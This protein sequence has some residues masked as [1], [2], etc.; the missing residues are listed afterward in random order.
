MEKRL[1]LAL[2]LSAMVLMVFSFLGPKKIT[3]NPAVKQ[4]AQESVKVE[5]AVL[6]PLSYLDHSGKEF[7]IETEVFKIVYSEKGGWIKNLFLKEYK[8]K[9][10]NAVDLINGEGTGGLW[11]NNKDLN[12]EDFKILHSNTMRGNKEVELS[13]LYPNG[14]EIKKNFIFTPNEYDFKFSLEF[15]NHSNE[16]IKLDSLYLQWGPGINVGEETKRERKMYSLLNISHGKELKRVKW[17]KLKEPLRLKDE[18]KWF[19]LNN[20][21]FLVALVPSEKES[22]LLVRKTEN[23]GIEV[24]WN[25]SVPAIAPN[26]KKKFEIGRASCRERV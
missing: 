11:F 10:G 20:K 6:A 16:E 5:E 17:A 19:G 23:K 8:D 7:T 26:G 25:V 3:Q 2:V 15:I 14:L 9:N 24:G 13:F 22:E 21:Y 12:Q 18:I 4:D 1:V